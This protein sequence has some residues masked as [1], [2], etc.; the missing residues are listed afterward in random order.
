MK[1][2]GSKLVFLGVVLV[3]GPLFGIGIRG[4]EDL[5]FSGCFILGIISIAIGVI[6]NSVSNNKEK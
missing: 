4:L 5:N 3:I 6:M 2:F 1:R